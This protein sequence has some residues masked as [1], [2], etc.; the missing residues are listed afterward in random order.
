L[1]LKPVIY[2][3][4]LVTFMREAREAYISLRERKD[5]AACVSV[6]E[7]AYA[8][9][10]RRG[11]LLLLP[12]V[13]LETDIHVDGILGVL[14]ETLQIAERAVQEFDSMQELS[15]G[16]PSALEGWTEMH[17]KKI[18]CVLATVLNSFLCSG[19]IW[20]MRLRANPQMN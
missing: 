15:A 5:W 7:N 19:N 3:E 8:M 10:V 14:I 9:L 16:L 17:G 4:T 18:L 6:S 13:R 1:S 20:T 2:R 11:D 12:R